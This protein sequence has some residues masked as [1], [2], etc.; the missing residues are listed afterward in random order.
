[1][2]TALA[3]SPLLHV[4]AATLAPELHRHSGYVVLAKQLSQG[5]GQKISADA[6]PGH[7]PGRRLQAGG[8]RTAT[9][10][11]RSWVH[12]RRGSGRP[13][14]EYL[15]NSLLAGH[16]RQGDRHGVAVRRGAPAVER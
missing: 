10:P 12:Q 11:R 2:K 6:I 5:D 14:I 13:G 8:D 15:D 1:V 7:H 3:L 16:E 9:W 4:P